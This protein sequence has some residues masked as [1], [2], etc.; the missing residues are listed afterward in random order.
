MG[1]GLETQ[2]GLQHNF[3]YKNKFA[4][5]ATLKSYPQNGPQHNFLYKNKTGVFSPAF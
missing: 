4:L 2:N 3:L 5:R 1:S